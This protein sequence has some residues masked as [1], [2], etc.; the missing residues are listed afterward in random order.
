MKIIV[1]FIV[2]AELIFS[3]PEN[4]GPYQA[5]WSSVTLN[6]GGRNLD[7]PAF[8]LSRFF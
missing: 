7:C 4:P 6:R 3:L 1:L 8:L 2:L 5:G